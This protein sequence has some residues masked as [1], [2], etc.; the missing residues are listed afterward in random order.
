MDH[1]ERLHQQNPA[2]YAGRIGNY[3]L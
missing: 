2:L 3:T 1:I